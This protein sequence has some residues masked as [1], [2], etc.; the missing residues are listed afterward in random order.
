MNRRYLF[1]NEIINGY[2]ISDFYGKI[3]LFIFTT[4]AFD[5]LGPSLIKHF[6]D[7]LFLR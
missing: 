2:E 3:L 1:H 7:V 5:K 4:D 6:D